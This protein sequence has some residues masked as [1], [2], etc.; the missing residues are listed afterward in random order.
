M[1]T[2]RLLLATLF[3]ALACGS[4]LA[5]EPPAKKV[6]CL[7]EDNGAELLPLLTNP[8]GDGGEGQVES[9]TVFAGKSAVKI[10]VYQKY[11]NLLPG[12]AHQIREK[13]AEGQ[14]RYLRFAWKSSGAAGLML[15]LHDERDW[16][17][18]Y[19][20]G[21]NKFGWEAKA[22]AES[23]PNE[24][25][26]V[27]I[28]LFKDFGD[29]VIHGIALTAF[30]GV[31]YFDHIYLAPTIADLDAI[32]ATGLATGEPI[33]LTAEQLEEHFT[34]LSSPDASLA[35][36]AYWT[37]AAAGPL[38]RAFLE[39]KA[40]GAIE[41][42]D[43]AKI[44]AWIKELDHDEYAVRERATAA[45]AANIAAARAAIDE[46]LKR[47]TSFE[48]RSRLGMILEKAQS[49]I[50]GQERSKQQARQILASIAERAGR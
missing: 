29:R 22:V 26:L 20:A 37:L 41:K 25:T 48:T 44:A 1:P 34:K 14:Y 33:V 38:A 47:T 21:G 10:T 6:A 2:K 12:W 16:H 17:I 36:R 35:Y 15:Q 39:T 45:L 50:E 30:D 27:T 3:V 5:A 42:V 8:G 46:E 31:G 19:V 7:L 32:D 9:D 4:A 24:W 40:G 43:E 13:P 18:R 23:P 28:D 49:P 11:F